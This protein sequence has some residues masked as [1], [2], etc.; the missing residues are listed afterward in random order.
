MQSNCCV[1]IPA[2]QPGELLVSYVTELRAAIGCTIVIV[3]D[4]SGKTPAK[5]PR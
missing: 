5:G 3:D 4:G 2:Y 1:V